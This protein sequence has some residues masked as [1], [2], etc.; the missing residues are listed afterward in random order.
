MSGM[1]NP[2]SAA[3]T[4]WDQPWSAS[5]LQAVPRCP[6]CG[7]QARSVLYERLVDNV[8]FVA[9]G[10]W[11]LHQCKDCQSAYLDPR[12]D[13]ATIVNAYG[14][15]YTHVA[16][17]GRKPTA[18]LSRLRRLRRRLANGYLNRRHGTQRQP[19]STLGAVLLAGLPRVR[20]SLDVA[21]R[22]LARPRLGQTLLDVGCGNGGFLS[23]AAEAG[24]IV[25]GVDPDPKALAVAASLG[26]DVRQGGIETFDGEKARFDV[27]TLNHVIEHLHQPA[28]VIRAAWHLL[29][30]GGVLYIDTP[31]IQSRGLKRFGKNW[32]G[33]EAPRHLVLFSRKGLVNLLTHVGFQRLEFQRRS[34]VRTGMALSSLRMQR[35]LSPYDGQLSRLPW[36]LKLETLV[37]RSIDHDE[38][39]TILAY[40]AS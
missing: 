26:H 10:R 32:R 23:C 12:P 14:T 2:E 11:T 21:F 3:G 16:G 24:W 4:P 17:D 18:E 30:P 1:T 29:K 13:E 5:G 38:F 22:F 34:A 33:L 35:G 36:P 31:N 7:S 27:I 20:Q 39:L 40:K 8:F 25:S 19:A 6:G 37:P 15:Y 28:E 9:S